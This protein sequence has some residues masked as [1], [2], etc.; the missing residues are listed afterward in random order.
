MS[1]YRPAEG[2]YVGRPPCGE[3]GAAARLHGATGACP[4]AYRPGSLE[5]ARR[6]LER[7]VEAGDPAAEF[8]ARGEVQRLSR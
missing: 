3:C 5:E 2:I 6:E 4:L 8:V 1:S 7:A